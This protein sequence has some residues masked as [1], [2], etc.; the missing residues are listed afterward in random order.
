MKA[1]HEPDGT[2]S[3]DPAPPQ[4][5][6]EALFDEFRRLNGVHLSDAFALALT[7]RIYDELEAEDALEEIT[8]RGVRVVPEH[9][10]RRESSDSPS[11]PPTG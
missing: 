3:F 8:Y 2:V 10:E 1:I 5:G 7:Q 6:V 4:R 11:S 9:G